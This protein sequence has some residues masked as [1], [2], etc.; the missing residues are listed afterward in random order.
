[1]CV[2][3]FMC[4]FVHTTPANWQVYERERERERETE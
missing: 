3:V 1:V 2:C 4:V